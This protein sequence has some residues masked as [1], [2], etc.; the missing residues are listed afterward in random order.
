MSDVRHPTP[1]ARWAWYNL[2]M[3][4]EE[5]D[6]GLT[7]DALEPAEERQV[8]ELIAGRLVRLVLELNRDQKAEPE[9]AERVIAF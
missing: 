3:D 9:P 7:W 8:G 1:S 4:Q 2:G 5:I 6:D